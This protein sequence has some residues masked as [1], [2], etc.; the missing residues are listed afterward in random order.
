MKIIFTFILICYYSISFSQSLSENDIKKLAKELN[1]KLKGTSIE[2]GVT[3][4]GCYAIERTLVY[5]YDVTDDWYP[6]QSMKEDLLANFKE[7][8]ISDTY[9]NNEIDVDFQYYSGNILRKRISIKSN[10]F[11]N[12]NFTLGDYLS[13]KGHPKAKDVDFKIKI[14]V[15]WEIKEGDRPN[16]IK[17]FTH[18]GN[19]FLIIIKDNATFF[20]RNE[21]RQ[22]LKPDYVEELIAESSSSLKNTETLN[23]QIIT[24]DTYPAV[25]FTIRGNKESSGYDIRLIMKSWLIFYEDKIVL[26]QC[27]GLDGK[28][29]KT[30]ESL[31][32]LIAS[33]VIFPEQYD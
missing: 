5:L 22:F 33:S 32:N 4:Q 14:P 7:S 1:V 28:E 31:Y 8:G 2:N 11:S 27:A 20:S 16:V 6:P 21:A 25:E 23:S 18:K 10:E 26:L 9:F 29:F 13:I 12:L 24:I 30:L 17:T 15:G 3:V 19:T